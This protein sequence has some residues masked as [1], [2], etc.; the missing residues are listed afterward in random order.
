M[1][2]AIIRWSLHNRLVVLLS[3]AALIVWGALQ[4]Q[5][6]PVD[7]FP[8]LTAPT[9][10]VIAE[11]HGMAPEE[12]ERLITFQV[13]SAINGASG[14]RRV[15]SSTSVGV[16]VVWVEFEWGTDIYTARQ[17]VSEKL[18]LVQPS[19]PPDVAPP[20]LAPIS[21]IM[22]EILFV[23]LVSAQHS[24]RALRTLADWEVR[25]RLLAV[26][27]VS[28][29]VPIGGGVQ[30]F[31]VLVRPADL[32]RHGITLDEVVAAVRASN[33]NTSAGFYEQ[34][35]QEYLIYGLGRVGGTADIANAV[36]HRRRQRP[37]MADNAVAQDLPL[38]VLDVADVVIGDSIKRGDAAINGAAA[39]VLGIQKQ[40]GENTLALTARIDRVLTDIE[41]T[42]PEG[43]QLERRLL[44]QADFIETSVENV[45]VSL[46]DGA[47]LVILII[48]VF[49]LSGRATLITAL[50]IPLSLVV[51]VLVLKA[52]GESLNTMTLGG[53]AIAVGALVDDAIIDVE[54]VARRLRERFGGQPAAREQA[55]HA[56]QL[57]DV[58]FE[59]SKE[60]RSSVVFATLIIVLVFLPLFFLEG[61]EGRL[62]KPLGVAYVVSLA[63]SLAVALTVTPVLCAL[64]LP[65]SRAVKH[66][67][68]P[69]PVRWLRR[70]YEAILRRVVAAWPLWLAL[71]LAGVVA[72]GFAARSAG[73]TFLPEF[74]EGALTLSVVTFPGT[75]LQ[76]SNLLGHQ[77]E[78]I[79]L[80]HPEVVTTAR[81]TGRAELDEHAQGINASEIDVRLHMRDRSEAAFLAAL[82]ADFA[83]V[84]GANVVIGQPISH[85]IDH[86]ISGTRAN[87][88]VKIFGPDL[89]ELQRLAEAAKAQMAGVEGVVDLSVEAQANLPFVKI[90]FN[91]DA[92]ALHDLSVRDVSETIETA[93]YGTTVS[94]VL[95][96]PYAFDLLVR[97]PDSAREDLQAIKQ[98]LIPTAR[99]AWVP[100]E[101]L[102]EIQRDRGPNQISR[103]NGQRKIVAMCNVGDGRDL[104]SVV[105]EI[106]RKVGEGVPLPPGYYIEYGGQFEAA[107][108]AAT[109]LFWLSL[110]V[111]A[112]IFVLLFVAIGS[113]RD[114]LLVMANL[115]LALIGGVAGVFLSDG[116]I[117]IASVI[118]F[119]TLFGIATR[120][121]I[122]MVTHI[123]RLHA[124]EGVTNP[125]EAVIRGA[126]ERLAPILMTA[127]AS[128][129]GLLPLA[130]AAGEPGSEI[131]A[132][133]AIVILFGLATSTLLNMLV[134]PAMMLRFGSV[135]SRPVGGG[136][137]PGAPGHSAPG[138]NASG[139]N[140]SGSLATAR[141]GT[142]L[143]GAGETRWM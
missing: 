6:M 27:G 28:Q 133:M 29:V 76:Q 123:Q 127:L 16:A 5:R 117:S 80:G 35:G 10:T 44:R 114:T 26:P 94:R 57:L 140:A 37:G 112:G 56:R 31:Q 115:P 2:D 128:G 83:A 138:H 54:N 121:G 69:A 105:A 72:A 103:E 118:G 87:I 11:A 73:R 110:V 71:S 1:I 46:R 82:R 70:L 75:S 126:S 108:E 43:V 81:R 48:G 79:L 7:V 129:L 143:G 90:R 53:M 51:A 67:T 18:Q 106:E 34:A 137:G 63:A 85:R 139:A 100:I 58:V 102:A 49:L 19:L 15:R 99:G 92:L 64:L 61:V 86:M 3:A 111:V 8:D 96:G 68:E 131:Q 135:R 23:G 122:M 4:A 84:A 40:P 136:S 20:L 13:E 95:A 88:A 134:V 65:R 104:G 125:R 77:V 47:I 142:E 9:V 50:A 124:V 38:R 119:I 22:G 78:S 130:L 33:E 41:A 101:A 141:L 132:P 113:T 25:R 89:H 21:S 55:H 109:T 62:L 32:A 97:Y 60:I 116:I 74:N 59:A 98:T 14:V 120:N 66:G 39:V 107:T 12:V 93:F 42:L 52:M 91:R 17:I 24:P 36:V 30:Q 45:A